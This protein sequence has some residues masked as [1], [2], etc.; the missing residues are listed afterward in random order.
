MKL[1]KQYFWISSQCSSARRHTG[2]P[3][4][5]KWQST[6]A[7]PSPAQTPH[8]GRFLSYLMFIPPLEP[9]Y[10][11]FCQSQWWGRQG[12][13]WRVT[14]R[15]PPCFLQSQAAALQVLKYQGKDHSF[16]NQ[17][18]MIMLSCSPVYTCS[19]KN[20]TLYHA[21][22]SSIYSGCKKAAYL[23]WIKVVTHLPP[24]HRCDVLAQ[25][26]M[27]WARSMPADCPFHSEDRPE[28]L[29]INK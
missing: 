6:E 29:K 19:T 20:T 11:H 28:E 4:Q 5:R 22:Q 12:Q 14:C 25:G 3:V 13:R 2:H 21:N 1:G 16:G 17:Q 26:L 8:T 10:L 9:T 7:A 24:S 27:L 18:H 15:H 23:T